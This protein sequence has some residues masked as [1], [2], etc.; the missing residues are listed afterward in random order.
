[1]LPQLFSSFSQLVIAQDDLMAVRMPLGVTDMQ[2]PW[3]WIVKRLDDELVE[4]EPLDKRYR[5]PP[6]VEGRQQDV[7][8]LTARVLRATYPA[9][10]V[11]DAPRAV[12][13]GDVDSTEMMPH[14]LKD[15]LT[16]CAQCFNLLLSRRVVQTPLRRLARPR[17][18]YQTEVRG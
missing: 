14:R 15:I 6:V 5:L 8:C 17:E 1:M 11:V 12:T 2:P 3:P 16:E 18:L 13:R 4:V 9:D 7:R 10:S